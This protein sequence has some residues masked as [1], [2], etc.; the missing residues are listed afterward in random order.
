MKSNREEALVFGITGKTLSLSDTATDST[1]KTVTAACFIHPGQ[2]VIHAGI[3]MTIFAAT[4]AAQIIGIHMRAIGITMIRKLRRSTIATTAG[5]II[6]II[7]IDL[8]YRRMELNKALL[9]FFCGHFDAFILG[10]FQQCF[11]IFGGFALR[12]SSGVKLSI[13]K[14]PSPVEFLSAPT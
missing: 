11:H 10:K 3:V 14:S 5:Y 13:A 2:R 7:V 6:Q 4:G 12:I 9:C 1:G 8:A